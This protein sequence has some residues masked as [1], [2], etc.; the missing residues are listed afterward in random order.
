M[1]PSTP[2]WALLSSAA[3]PVLLIGGWT[4]AAHRQRAPFDA[5]RQTIS[6]LAGA[7]ADDRWIMTVALFGVGVC[8]VVTAA[9]LDRCAV[10]GRAVLAAGGVTT[11]LTAALPLPAAGPAP[12][13]AAA[14]TA[15]FVTLAVWPA[16]AVRPGDGS[17]RRGRP[18]VRPA[19]AFAATGVLCALVVWT[20]VSLRTGDRA[21]LAERVTAGAVSGWPL[22]MA[23]RTRRAGR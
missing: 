15:A 19:V 18:G 20:A 4:L 1:R 14:A 22:V 8:H 13:H 16:L 7:S 5:T 6:A 3:A 9:G 23:L 11:A 2:W 17:S 12:G 10:A 21:G